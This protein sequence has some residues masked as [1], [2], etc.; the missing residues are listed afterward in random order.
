MLTQTQKEKGK[1]TSQEGRL[2]EP[3]K[4]RDKMVNISEVGRLAP[5]VLNEDTEGGSFSYWV[6]ADDSRYWIPQKRTG[7]HT[8][9]HSTKHGLWSSKKWGCDSW[10]AACFTDEEIWRHVTLSNRTWLQLETPVFEMELGTSDTGEWERCEKELVVKASWD[11]R[12]CSRRLSLFI[13]GKTHSCLRAINNFISNGPRKQSSVPI[14]M[15][16]LWQ[17][18]IKN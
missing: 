12:P 18:K 13:G 6:S 14:G 7:K 17:Y 2:A 10:W 4:P 15:K 16:E 9:G 3:S 1:I 11:F 8:E 5:R